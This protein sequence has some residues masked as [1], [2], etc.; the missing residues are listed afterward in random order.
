MLDHPL[1]TLL[2]DPVLP[3]T[4]NGVACAIWLLIAMSAAACLVSK[5]K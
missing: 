5:L 2:F 1:I 3:H 4:I